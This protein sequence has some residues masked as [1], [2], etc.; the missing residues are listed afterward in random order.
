MKSPAKMGNPEAIMKA[1]ASNANKKAAEPKPK[2]KP[3]PD[4]IIA[5][6]K[7]ADAKLKNNLDRI[8]KEKT[9]K[10]KVSK[11]KSAKENTDKYN[12][13]KAV[14]TSKDKSND[15]MYGSWT[16]REKANKTL[17][18]LASGGYKAPVAKPTAKPAAK[19]V[20]KPAAKPANDGYAKANKGGAMDKLVKARNSATKGSREYA[21]AQNQI[22]AALGSKVKYSADKI[23]SV[24]TLKPRDITGNG[25]ETI[26]G[27]MEKNITIKAPLP[28]IGKMKKKC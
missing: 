27:P 23:K 2:P 25:N 20:A 4:F 15:K 24:S 16:N 22:N 10:D 26:A 21:T 7:A 11:E 5:N 12:K 3:V 18:E 1:K 28:A 19:P 14:S 13:A 6:R 17:K 8:S 9:A